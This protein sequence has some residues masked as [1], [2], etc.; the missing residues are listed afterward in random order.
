MLPS[1]H[2]VQANLEFRGCA[3]IS[4]CW[5]SQR[6]LSWQWLQAQQNRPLKSEWI[7]HPEGMLASAVP[8]QDVGGP[9]RGDC[10]SSQV[11]ERD[12]WRLTKRREEKKETKRMNACKLYVL[13]FSLTRK[14]YKQLSRHSY[15]RNCDESSLF[16]TIRFSL[17]ILC[18]AGQNDLLLYFGTSEFY[19]TVASMFSAVPK[20]SRSVVPL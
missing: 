14:Y 7:N 6:V 15:S 18:P 5:W 16:I 19:S 1:R 2:Q 9:K 10:C 13:E 11:A 3:F 12:V 4:W 17:N 8:L 20:L